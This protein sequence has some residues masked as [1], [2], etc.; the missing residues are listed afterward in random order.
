MNDANLEA[1]NETLIS[2]LC[3]LDNRLR[4][5]FATKIRHYALYNHTLAVLNEF[6]KYFANW[7]L[8]DILSRD[9]MRLFLALHDIGKPFAYQDGN[10]SKQHQY[11]LQ[12]LND[13]KVNLGV[14][15]GEFNLFTALSANDPLGKYF[16]SA[17]SS[18][19][20]SDLIIS[21]AKDNHIVI[22]DYL[23]ILTVYFQV[24]AGSYTK[25]AGGLPYLEKL[26][27]YNNGNKVLHECGTRLIFNSELEKKYNELKKQLGL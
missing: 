10:K 24:D 1:S 14:N 16:Q 12:I 6:N 11:T 4:E 3:Q 23:E 15:D 18:L 8:K 9:K 26:F 19:L 22:Q 20:T 21:I 27:V 25:D 2:N 13:I 7:I 5:L 17:I